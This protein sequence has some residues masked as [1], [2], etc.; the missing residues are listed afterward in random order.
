LAFKNRFGNDDTKIHL[1]MDKVE[2]S[3]PLMKDYR[4]KR[5]LIRKKIHYLEKKE[6]PCP[7]S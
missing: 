1:Y 3:I 4:N 2:G 6:G 7:S 5:Y